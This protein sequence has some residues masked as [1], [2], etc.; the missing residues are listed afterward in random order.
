MGF[1]LKRSGV[2]SCLLL[3]LILLPARFS[4]A[5]PEVLALV[6]NE[7]I[8]TYDVSQRIRLNS[9]LERGG[10]G[11]SRDHV[12]SELVDEG[13]R[14]AEA[15]RL[16]F[17]LTEPQLDEAIDHLST[18]LKTNPKALMAR[19]RK[20]GL[21][22]ETFRQYVEA[23]LLLRAFV[24]QKGGED[25]KVEPQDV[26]ARLKRLSSDPRFQPV[27]LYAIVQVDLPVEETGGAINSQLVYARMVEAQQIAERYT[28]CGSL[29]AAAAPIYNVKISKPIAAVSDKIPPP[30]RKALLEAGTKK[31]I[32]P[33]QAPGGV[34]LI[35]FC[36][37]KT[38][39]PP[40]PDRKVI[41]QIVLNEK[42]QDISDTLMRDLRQKVLI[43]P[44]TAWARKILQ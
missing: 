16:G 34:Q 13:V 41:E 8:T 14:R 29:K 43:E 18:S 25:F 22:E 40:K 26:D 4:V 23:S 35:A 3:A 11:Q 10:G 44:K 39:S 17:S 19:L 32:G 37:Q 1:F 27:T 28:G 6:N 42:M 5:A 2:F 36:G 20:A 9:L 33:I 30:M 12:F 24:A 31:L 21:S 7:P 38:V 15:S